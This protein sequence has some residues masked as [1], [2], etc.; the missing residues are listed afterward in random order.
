V[1]TLLNEA[2]E[3]D[4][5]LEDYLGADSELLSLANGVFSTFIGTT[6]T[7]LP[8]VRFFLIEQDDLMVVNA[9]RVWAELVYQVE[10]VTEGPDTTEALAISQRIDQ[11]LHR[12]QGES[13]ATVFVQEVFRRQ[14][15]FSKTVES[16]DP[17]VYAGGEYVFRVSALP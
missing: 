14:P 8:V 6:S 16:G 1:S 2:A 15:L 3:T 7:K 11:L 13:S 12:L 9:N 17:F 4:A 5:W 10:A